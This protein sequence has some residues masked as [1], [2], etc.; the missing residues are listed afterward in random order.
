MGA[1]V[2]LEGLAQFGH[3]PLL[4]QARSGPFAGR[5]SHDKTKT[6]T[7]SCPNLARLPPFSHKYVIF[8]L[9]LDSKVC[10][11]EEQGKKACGDAI[12]TISFE[13]ECGS[14]KSR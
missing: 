8:F 13:K 6:K 11:V 5:G 1:R 9:D 4:V 12:Y 2:L 14:E 10:M 3:A 7:E